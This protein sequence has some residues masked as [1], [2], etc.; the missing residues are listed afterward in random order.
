MALITDEFASRFFSSNLCRFVAKY[1][2]ALY[3]HNV[4]HKARQGRSAPQC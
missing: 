3:G 4:P 1:I 2:L